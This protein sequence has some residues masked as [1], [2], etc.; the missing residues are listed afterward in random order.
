MPMGKNKGAKTKLWGQNK[1]ATRLE[2]MQGH[3]MKGTIKL[4][5]AMR[6]KQ[7]PEK[8]GTKQESS[9]FIRKG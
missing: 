6:K 4:K 3:R 5:R 2:A 9:A 8:A 1:G 7:T